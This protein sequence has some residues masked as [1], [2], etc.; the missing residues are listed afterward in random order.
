MPYQDWEEWH[1]AGGNGVGT[2]EAYP[3]TVLSV[4]LG[5][6]EWV[7]VCMPTGLRRPAL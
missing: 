4:H 2:H 1:V 5:P 6:G 3:P 7:P